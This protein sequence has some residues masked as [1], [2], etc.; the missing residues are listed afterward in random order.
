M[1]LSQA[2]SKYLFFQACADQ[3]PT[4]KFRR[5]FCISLE[6]SLPL[7][8]DSG[9]V[10]LTTLT[11]RNSDLCLF[12]ALRTLSSPWVSLPVLGLGKCFQT[13]GWD[14][15]RALLVCFLFSGVTGLYCQLPSVE[16]IFSG[17]VTSC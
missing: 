4:K 17:R 7:T 5:A 1:V 14:S 15:Y 8:A 12:S 11:S 2:T 9:L 3:Y 6:L 13:L 16:G 10:N